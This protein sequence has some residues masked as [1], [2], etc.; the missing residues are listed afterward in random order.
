MF[1][2]KITENEAGQRVD[3][4]LRKFLKDYSLGDIYRLFR[5]NRIKVNGAR[6]KEN[7]M[8]NEGDL[9]QLYIEM[10]KTEEARKLPL[11]KPDKGL[12]IIYEDDNILIVGK[13]AGMLTHP[14]KPGDTDTLIDRALSHIYSQDGSVCKSRTFSPAACNRLDRNTSGIVIIAKNYKTLKAVNH[15][16]RERRIKKLYL[17]IV[18]GKMIKFGEIKGFLKKDEDRNLVAVKEADSGEGKQIHTIYRTLGIS[19]RIEEPGEQFSLLEVELVTGRSHQIRA[20]FAS[21]GHPVAGDVKYGDMA[22]NRYFRKRYNLKHQFLH[23]YRVT[24]EGVHEDIGYLNGKSFDSRLDKEA[25]A[26]TD[27]LFKKVNI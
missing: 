5:K 15:S 20:H 25:A 9:L 4:F 23:A 2:V 1:E 27:S 24:F 16:I 21:L 6:T 3:R 14:D 22:I 13:P 7:Y 17:C 26:I 12:D 19:E 11:L 8:L 10:P 18:A